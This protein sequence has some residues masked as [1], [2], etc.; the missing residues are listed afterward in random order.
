[1]V[2]NVNGNASS[3]IAISQGMRENISIVS[4]LLIVICSFNAFYRFF[5]RV[6]INLLLIVFLIKHYIPE[7]LKFSIQR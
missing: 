5:G 3:M 6:F 1:M 7:G 4:I 2:N